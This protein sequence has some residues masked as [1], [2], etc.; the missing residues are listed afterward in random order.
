[1]VHFAH[2]LNCCAVRSLW[3]V[4]HERCVTTPEAMHT[5]APARV[6]QCILAHTT[7]HVNLC[8][9]TAAQKGN[10]YFRLAKKRKTNERTNTDREITIA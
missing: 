1:M 9:P 10:T 8:G 2:R 6:Q 4:K 5:H 3:R 7:H